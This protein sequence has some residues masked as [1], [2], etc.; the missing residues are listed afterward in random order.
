MVVLTDPAECGPVTL[1]FCQDVQAEAYDYPESFFE[2]RL[3]TPAPHAPRRERTGRRRRRRCAS[4]KKPVIIAGGGVL[5]S[6]ASATLAGFAA[7]HGIPVVETQGGKSS[8]PFTDPLEH[9]GGRRH[10]H[11]GCEPAVRAGGR[12]PRGGH[13]AAGLHHRLLGAVP[14]SGEDH[15]RPQHAGVRRHQAPR[16]AAGG[17]CA[18]GPRGAFRQS[19]RLGGARGLDGGRQG[20]LHGVD[21][22]G[23]HLHRTP[24]MPSGRR[25]RR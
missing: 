1:A 13:A 4:A 14:E 6:E 21:G 22:D 18:R 16:P 17:R 9:G 20:G 11:G 24:P 19:R 23:R 15:H 25:T 5:F 10:R 8:L 12:D 3:W 7:K 2:E